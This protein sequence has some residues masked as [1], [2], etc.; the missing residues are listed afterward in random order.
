DGK[1]KKCT[2]SNKG[3]NTTNMRLHLNN[4]HPEQLKQLQSEELKIAE[5]TLNSSSRSSSVTS[6]FKSKSFGV[7][8]HKRNPL[9]Q[10]STS[11][12]TL[13]LDLTRLCA[14]TSFPLSMVES[15]E[16]QKLIHNLDSRSADSLP[17]RNTLKNW[18]VK[19][20]EDIMKKVISNLQ[21]VKNYF[22]SMD[23]WSQ[24]GLDKFY[25]G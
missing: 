3:R 17:C 15:E 25:L 13:K 10:N 11:F 19:Y 20:S 24:P 14:C 8:V 23:I 16:F 21:L 12:Q 6:F 7:P 1:E 2:Y 22:L 18:V 9:P 5:Q 4:Y